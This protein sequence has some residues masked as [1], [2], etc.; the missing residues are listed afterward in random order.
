[1]KTS[2]N[3]FSR[4]CRVCASVRLFP[5]RRAQ[6]RISRSVVFI[7]WYFVR[8]WM[9]RYARIQYMGRRWQLKFFWLLCFY[10]R[11]RIHLMNIIHNCCIVN[12]F[13]FRLRRLG[14][15]QWTLV[16]MNIDRLVA[17]SW[18]F[19]ARSHVT[20]RVT[21]L[22]LL[23]IVLFTF[24]NGFFG[25]SFYGVVRTTNNLI[26]KS[27][28]GYNKGSGMNIIVFRINVFNFLQI[29]KNKNSKIKVNSYLY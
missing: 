19:L 7:H 27:C 29:N 22:V 23:I 9:H 18:P 6:L 2:H 10:L 24:A 28:T 17:I 16:A 8:C 26:G 15:V 11:I 25:I 4:R 21:L 13:Y 20:Q 3:K 12:H 5:R 14:V 1:M